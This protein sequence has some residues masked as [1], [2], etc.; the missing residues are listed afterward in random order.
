MKREIGILTF[1]LY[2]I[3]LVLLVC[4]VSVLFVPGCVGRWRQ[5]AFGFDAGRAG[6]HRQCRLSRRNNYNIMDEDNAMLLMKCE[7]H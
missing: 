1:I 5:L 7:M 2:S 6:L 4:F 3:V